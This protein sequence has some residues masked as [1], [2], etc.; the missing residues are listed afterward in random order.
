MLQATKKRLYKEGLYS[1]R[2]PQ[3]D[4]TKWTIK[5]WCDWIDEHGTWWKS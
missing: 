1:C 5:Q 4:T 2:G 3:G